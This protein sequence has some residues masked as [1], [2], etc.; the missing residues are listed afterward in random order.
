MSLEDLKLQIETTLCTTEK[1]F[2]LGELRVLAVL[3]LLLV[4]PTGSRPGAILGL[5][6]GDIQVSLMRDPNGGPHR[7]VIACTLNKTKTYKGKKEPYVQPHPE[8]HVLN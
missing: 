6:F 8:L 1:S 4:C 2:K 3:F 5:Q 7:L